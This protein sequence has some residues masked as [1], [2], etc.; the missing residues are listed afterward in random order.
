MD[1]PVVAAGGC[2]ERR[3][4]AGRDMDGRDDEHARGPVAARDA[5]RDVR[6]ARGRRCADGLYVD[7]AAGRGVRAARAVDSLVGRRR[8]LAG[9]R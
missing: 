7:G 2:V 1:R 6:A 8:R 5:G 9:C 4:S 3:R